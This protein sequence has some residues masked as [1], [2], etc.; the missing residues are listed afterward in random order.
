MA[1][2]IFEVLEG[3]DNISITMHI[4]QS[5]RASP[6][7]AT[8]VLQTVHCIWNM[9]HSSLSLAIQNVLN[10]GGGTSTVNR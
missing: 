8:L 10:M 7:G 4:Q 1:Q 3:K 6:L 2:A 5:K 9:P